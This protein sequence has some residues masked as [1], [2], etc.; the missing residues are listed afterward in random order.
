MRKV[1][2]TILTLVL[3]LGLTLPMA[4]PAAAHTEAAPFPTQL[5][6]GQ[7]IPVGEVNVWND[8]T[9][10]Y[11]QFITEGGWQLVETNLAVATSLEGIPQTGS[12]NPKV[13]KFPYKDDP[14]GTYEIPLAWSAGT[15]LY[16]A[17]HAVVYN[18]CLD[19][20]ETA[21]AFYCNT[22]AFPGRNWATYFV[23]TVQDGGG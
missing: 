22:W 3:I 10:L 6:A 4:T 11:V 19:Q 16:I 20:E 9:N 7:N 2:L 15:R 5:Y 14:D 12:G 23:Y 1:I 8:G 17:A 21:W 13:G 18:P